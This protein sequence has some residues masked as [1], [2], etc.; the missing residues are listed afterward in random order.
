MT[1]I[2]DTHAFVWWVTSDPRISPS[3]F[4]ILTEDRLRYLSAVTAFELTNKLRIGKLE[5]GQ[6]LVERLDE[7]VRNAHFAVLPVA[8]SHAYLAGKMPGEP[9][10]PFDR[11]IAAQAKIEQIPILSADPAFER[12]GVETI[13]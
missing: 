6:E 13:W 10:D 4:K 3:V 11:L 1:I 5:N 8:L 7:L 9:R 12:L 2:V